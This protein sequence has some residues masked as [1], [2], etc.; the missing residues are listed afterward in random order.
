MSRAFLLSALLF[1]GNAGA[2]DLKP[3]MMDSFRLGSG[4]GVLCQAQSRAVDPA[5]AG[6]F[7]RSWTLVCRDA[8][9][10]VG[11]LYALRADGGDIEA[12]LEASRA[13]KVT[14][15]APGRTQIG[16]LGDVTTRMCTIADA[17]LGYVI[18]SY[19]D[20]KT[21]YYVQGFASYDSAL[22]L[23]LRTIAADRIVDGPITIATSGSDDPAAFARLQASTLDPQTSLAEGYRR[24]NSGNY[25]EAAEFFDTLQERLNEPDEAKLTPAEREAR[26]HEYTINKA[27]QLS[28]LSEFEQAGALFAKAAQMATLDPVQVRLRRNFE[29]MHQ[30][31]Q[32]HYAAAMAIL[33]RPVLPIGQSVI[34][35]NSGIDLSP[36]LA[37]EINST[38]PA[39]RVMGVT[40]AARLTPDERA[41]IIDAQAG[42]LRGTVLRLQGKPGEARKLLEN[43]LENAIAVR[44]GRV[45]SITRLRAQILA[46]IALTHEAE[47]NFGAADTF[48]R[49][50]LALLSAS[51]PETAAMDGARA[52]LAA[53]L[54][55][56]GRNDEALG[57][58]R[59]IVASATANQAVVTGL[60]NQLQ[61]YFDLL[62]SQ[63]PARPEL[64][65][66]MFLASQILVRPGAA[67]TLE[68]LSR[69]LQSGDD[70]AARLFRQSVS[71]SR[72]IE[73]ARIELAELIQL[74][75]QDPTAVPLIDGARRDIDTLSR[76]QLETQVALAAYPQYRAVSREAV[77]LS[78][79]Q[80][81]LKPGE[82]YM[83]LV[84]VGGGMYAVYAD[85]Q[86][87]TGY[88]LPISSAELNTKVDG[89]RET[90]SMVVAG[91]QVTYPFD[92]ELARALYLDLFGPVD[93]RVA[94]VSHLIF[95]P[96]GAMLRLPPNLL[97]T[98]QAGADAYLQHLQDPSAD[99]FDFRGIQWLGRN[100]A[101]STAISVR[102]FRDARSSA[103]SSA[104]RQYLG[105]GHNAPVSAMVSTAAT[106][107]ASGA[108]GPD[109]RWPIEEWNRPIAATEL[110]QAANLLGPNGTKVVTD[111]AFTDTAIMARKDLSDY[112]IVHFATHGLVTAPQSGCPARPALLTSFGQGSSDGLLN[113]SEI[114]DLHLDADLVILSACDTAGQASKEA[115]RA[116]G[117]GTGGG[118][119]LDGLVRAFIGAGGRAVIASHWPA[120]DDFNATQRLIGGLFSGG[121]GE[122]IGQALQRAQA[123]L[124]DDAATS[125]PFYWSGFAIVG[126]GARPLLAGK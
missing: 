109:C 92:V 51:Y 88:R 2:Q 100:R 3:R 23:A 71:L 34:T 108:A 37:A 91:V 28:N 24:N 16:E 32:R 81:V 59:Q 111:A 119:A 82:A 12:R 79:L 36:Q 56:R 116:A 67:D 64:A 25:A 72:D 8:A 50:A 74:G 58:Y 44:D 95:E 75:A 26:Q 40:Q 99:E 87:V 18:H 62:S 13:A 89:L 94:T 105:F 78:D 65:G 61:P 6:M 47:G 83:K 73:R 52:R 45:T 43:A 20:G 48:L 84:R 69:E 9:K 27:L 110:R 104:P 4:G 21:T 98:E 33:D 77:T 57:L 126:D 68:V 55:R 5:I 19:K 115:T 49:D 107:S 41:A 35:S 1:T 54:V 17:D 7:D 80:A 66:D 101:I 86:G 85:A 14:C 118:S 46:E 97:I 11:Q 103:A 15:A 70:E 106:R 113:F 39:D 53:F 121:S 38:T 125:H 114:F 30:L 93:A 96:D 31:N 112:R 22:Q 102:G 123:P 29:A 117:L 90:I 76:Q 10:P 60:A 124:M 63:I 42:Q 120:P 122:N